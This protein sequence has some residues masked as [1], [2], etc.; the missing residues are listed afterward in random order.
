MNSEDMPEENADQSDDE[1][2]VIS[3]I[4]EASGNGQAIQPNLIKSPEEKG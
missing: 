4:G 1:D 3:Q 2:V